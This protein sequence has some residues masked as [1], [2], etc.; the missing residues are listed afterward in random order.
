[1]IEKIS[2]KTNE[3][4]KPLIMSTENLESMINNSSPSKSEIV[5]LGFSLKLFSD[6]IMLSDETATSKNFSRILNWLK[7][8]LKNN[9]FDNN[10]INKNNKTQFN[11]WDL[12]QNINHEKTNLVI[13]T[14]KGYAINKILTI[15]PN[16]KIFVFSDNHKVLNTSEFI[17]NCYCKITKKFPNNM[18]SFIFKTIKQ[19]KKII[20]SNG[21][22]TLLIYVAFPRAKSRANTISSI[23]SKDF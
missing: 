14:R 15:K 7:N 22:D 13:F 20:F 23:S 1:M 5:S 4:G 9:H 12:M 11:L 10:K 16:I 21:N 8:F 19:N 3:K 18:D 2:K 17:S 6:V